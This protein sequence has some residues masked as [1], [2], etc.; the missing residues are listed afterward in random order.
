[1]SR[2]ELENCLFRE[3]KFD[4]FGFEFVG[5]LGTIFDRSGIMIDIYVT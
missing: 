1:M 5:G 3:L 4:S 2:D